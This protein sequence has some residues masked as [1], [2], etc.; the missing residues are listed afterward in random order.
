MQWFDLTLKVQSAL[1]TRLSAD[2]L[3]GHLCWAIRYRQG[4]Q[5]LKEFLDGYK[6][7]SPPLVLSDPFPVDFWP[8]P[9]LPRPRPQEEQK[10]K[11]IISSEQKTKLDKTL[12]ICPVI[13]RMQTAQPTPVETF[14]ILKWLYQLRW[15]P[16]PVL[17]GVIDQLSMA[18]ILSFFVDKGCGQPVMPT[19][20]VVAHNT[21]NRMSGTTGDEGSFFFTRELHIDP[22]NPPVFHLLAG[23]DRYSHNQIK[24]LFEA[25]LEG[26]Y[27]KY[28]SRGKGKVAVEAIRPVEL[29]RAKNPN[30]VMLL[31]NCVPAAEDPTDGFWKLTTKSGRL[32]GDWA[33]G[34]HPS[35]T[36]NHKKKPLTLLTAGTI[37]KTTTPRAFYGRMVDGIHPDFPE[38]CHYGLAPAISV[39]CDFK[40]EL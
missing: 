31:A 18:S 20:E 37:F 14:D 36:N 29:P 7:G 2:T 5:A 40:E 25:A 6:A 17:D 11:M 23:S 38:V 3:F 34:P 4:E 9:T 22:A 15:L 10:L 12:K 13:H 26:G 28:K 39:C 8:L 33:V 32:G 24:D 30:A 1:G 27:G 21:I 19:E 35:V 16:Q